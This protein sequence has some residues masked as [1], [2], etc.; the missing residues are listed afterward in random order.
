MT[1]YLRGRP[2]SAR[3]FILRRLSSKGIA[4]D[5]SDLDLMP[6]D[7]VIALGRLLSTAS[8][9]SY[10]GGLRDEVSV[11]GF[12]VGIAKLKAWDG[13]T[14]LGKLCAE[15]MT[16][17]SFGSIRCIDRVYPI[18]SIMACHADPVSL[19]SRYASS[20]CPELGLVIMMQ[21]DQGRVDLSD[22]LMTHLA[23]KDC[24]A[25]VALL[26]ARALDKHKEDPSP[27]LRAMLGAFSGGNLM[28]IVPSFIRQM[29]GSSRDGLAGRRALFELMDPDATARLNEIVG[30]MLASPMSMSNLDADERECLRALGRS[31]VARSRVRLAAQNVPSMSMP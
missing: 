5:Q 21:M 29:R 27:A 1:H 14:Y 23:R 6:Q 2:V 22:R 28:D 18:A 9:S 11:D 19:T 16:D 12:Q 31:L 7:A 17:G 13:E 3:Q 20:M 15:R 4:L 26:L 8:A 25:G 10:V 30:R 24:S